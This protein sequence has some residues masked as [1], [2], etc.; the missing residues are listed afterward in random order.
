M[1]RCNGDRIRKQL[2]ELADISK[3]PDGINREGI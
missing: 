1:I 3:T 2:C